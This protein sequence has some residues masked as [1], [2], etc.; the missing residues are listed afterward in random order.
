M[1]CL[2]KEKAQK[3]HNNKKKKKK[4]LLCSD[5]Q[6]PES[7][8]RL[9]NSIVKKRNPQ[10]QKER[11]HRTVHEKQSTVVHFTRES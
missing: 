7:I 8:I 2:T 5:L 11:D 10:N 3:E 1:L 9:V 4:N 6:E